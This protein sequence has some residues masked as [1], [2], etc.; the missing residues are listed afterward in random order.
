MAY[1]AAVL[2]A[3]VFAPLTTLAKWAWYWRIIVRTKERRPLR[4]GD[5]KRFLYAFLAT[6]ACLW[7]VFLYAPATPA[8]DYSGKKFEAL[9]LWPYFPFVALCG[10]HMLA[11]F[12]FVFPIFVF[13]LAKS[14]TTHHT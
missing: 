7:V 4:Q 12:I 10:A 9:L 13:K 14:R 11:A 1:T 5:F 2:T 3:V 8:D 6:I